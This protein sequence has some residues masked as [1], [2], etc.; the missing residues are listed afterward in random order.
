MPLLTD[1]YKYLSLV[2]SAAEP[3]NGQIYEL[4]VEEFVVKLVCVMCVFACLFSL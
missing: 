1:F 4:S 3:F 2:M